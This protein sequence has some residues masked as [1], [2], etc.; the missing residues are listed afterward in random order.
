MSDPLHISAMKNKKNT[1]DWRIWMRAIRPFAYPASIVPALLGTVLGYQS[2]G[3]INIMYALIMMLGVLFT[4]TGAN[5]LADYADYKKGVD[6]M[7]TFGGSGVLVEKLLQPSRVKMAGLIC[8]FVGALSAC[9]F[10]WQ[11]GSAILIWI[12]IGGFCAFFYA[13]PPLELK[14][15]A[16]GD[17]LVFIAFGIGLT[18]GAYYV[19]VRSVEMPIFIMSIPF[20][21]L[22]IAILQANHLRDYMDDKAAGIVTS[23]GLLGMRYGRYSYSCV[24]M[25]ALL[26]SI[27]I[28]CY[29]PMGKGAYASVITLPLALR[30]IKLV[31]NSYANTKMQLRDLDAMTAQFA[32]LFGLSMILGISL[33]RFL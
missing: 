14:Y 6:R 19:Q 21:L 15:H 11:L 24:I 22:V 13:M 33:Y 5:L 4:H 31:H 25:I 18:T 29:L 27:L 9:F 12:L 8:L 16:L 2:T 32:M 28:G 26:S 3:T 23:I 7:G 30:C 10:I 17:I 20:G 1:I